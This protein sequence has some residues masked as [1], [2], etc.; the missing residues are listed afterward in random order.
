MAKSR[1][2]WCCPRFSCLNLH[3]YQ[4]WKQICWIITSLTM[5][6]V[7]LLKM[8]LK[9][10]PPF[11]VLWAAML[12]ASTPLSWIFSEVEAGAAADKKE[13]K[14]KR[15]RQ[16]KGEMRKTEAKEPA[17]NELLCTHPFPRSL[18]SVLQQPFQYK[19]GNGAQMTSPNLAVS[20]SWVKKL[21]N[22]GM[23]AVTLQKQST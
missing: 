13:E 8:A 7:L 14:L 16:D 15:G 10:F 22:W 18:F 6:L 23:L 2:K 1:T 11:F 20:Y 4:Q 12:S 9:G 19:M 17:L 3:F 21:Q 5:S